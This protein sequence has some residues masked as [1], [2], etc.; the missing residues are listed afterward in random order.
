MTLRSLTL[1]IFVPTLLVGLAV[2]ALPK[3]GDEVSDLDASKLTGGCDYHYQVS[4]C[5]NPEVC[6][7]GSGYIDTSQGFDGQVDASSAYP[8]QGLSDCGTV[9]TSATPC[10]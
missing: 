10:S 8:C 6:P 9:Y 2:F 7:Y 4:G 5:P 1:V 3:G